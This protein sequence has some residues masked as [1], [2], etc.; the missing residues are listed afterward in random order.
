[1]NRRITFAILSIYISSKFY[2]NLDIFA[3][4][5]DYSKV[6]R[7]CLEIVS[8]IN[9]KLKSIVKIKNW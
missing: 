2:E 9:R 3:L 1:M 7:S 4:F 5:A 8:Y 6:Q